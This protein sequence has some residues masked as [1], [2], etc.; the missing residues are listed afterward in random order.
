[1]VEFRYADE[2]TVTET[3]KSSEEESAEFVEAL[4]SFRKGVKKIW[5]G[6]GV[7]ADELDDLEAALLRSDVSMET[8]EKILDPLRENPDIDSA[9]DYIRDSVKS[10]FEKAGSRALIKA[11]SGPSI[12]FFNGV[13]GSG[14][15]TSMAKLA[16]L[17][18]PEHDILFA[19]G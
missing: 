11:R 19:A 14:K 16:D 13:N 17:L 7:S 6:S 12:Y 3:V 10:I 2:E 1:M 4:G 9:E 5:P 8:V 15:T 18:Q